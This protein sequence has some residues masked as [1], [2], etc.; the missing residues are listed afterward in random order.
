[1]GIPLTVELG[2]PTF[3]RNDLLVIEVQVAYQI[4][5]F[6]ATSLMIGKQGSTPVA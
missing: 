6:N 5:A 1:M 3:I 2:Y 4:S